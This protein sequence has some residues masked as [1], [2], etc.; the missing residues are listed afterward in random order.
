MIPSYFKTG[1]K[2]DINFLH[3]NT[4]KKYKSSYYNY[5]GNGIFEI[6]MPTDGGK[7]VLFSVGYEC[8]LYFQTSGGLFTCEA[9]VV[10]RYKKDNA[11]L[12]AMKMKTTMKKFQRREFFRVECLIDFTYYK[13]TEEIAALDSSL[14]LCKMTLTPELIMEQRMARTRDISGGGLRFTAEENLKAGQL[15]LIEIQ[16]TNDKVDQ[17]FYLVSEVVSCEAALE[18]SDRWIAR[19]KFQHKDPKER[20]AIIRFVFEHD[21]ELRKKR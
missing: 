3:Q 5:L 11:Y 19:V 6:T 9:V 16:L 2:I 12:L 17:T 14:E 8:Q 4:D 13:I 7:M 21:R 18:K 15:I 20:D 1:D 10:Q